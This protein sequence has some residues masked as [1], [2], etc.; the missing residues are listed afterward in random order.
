MTPRE[1]YN[2]YIAS[3]WWKQR[4]LKHLEQMPLCQICGTDRYLQVHH[5]S[6]MRKGREKK[7]QLFT[8][9]K[10]CHFG[11][12]DVQKSGISKRKLYSFTKHAIKMVK[13]I[14]QGDSNVDSYWRDILD[15]ILSYPIKSGII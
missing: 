3:D 12:H 6:Y 2:A 8:L 1:R 10:R 15:K 11:L 4:R 7:K 13:R 9:C 14:N 5:G